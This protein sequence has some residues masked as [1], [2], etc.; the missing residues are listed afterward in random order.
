MAQTINLRPLQ[1]GDACYLT[2]HHNREGECI[3][4]VMMHDGAPTA[5]AAEE[6]ILCA[7]LDEERVP[8]G[9]HGVEIADVVACGK[10]CAAEWVL[11]QADMPEETDR[12]TTGGDQSE[13][14]LEC[15]ILATWEV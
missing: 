5:Q 4:T 15:H 7:L 11:A 3:T 10:W 12:D 6:A 8:Y 1:T 2:D 14:Y 9:E 13:R